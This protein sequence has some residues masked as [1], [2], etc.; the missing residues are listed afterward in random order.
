MKQYFKSGKDYREILK[1]PT[2]DWG[3]VIDGKKLNPFFQII[4]N[5]LRKGAPSTFRKFPWT[6]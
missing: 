1:V 5:M 2:V 4:I 3:E 6:V